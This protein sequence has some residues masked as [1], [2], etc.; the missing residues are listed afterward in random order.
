MGCYPNYHVICIFFG[1]WY[2]SY[3]MPEKFDFRQRLQ[4]ATNRFV[5]YAHNATNEL[6]NLLDKEY[7]CLVTSEK[8]RKL[9]LHLQ[10]HFVSEVV[11][12]LAQPDM[13]RPMGLDPF[14]MALFH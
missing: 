2:N 5:W 6:R 3:P 4:L 7:Y 11:P 8:Q 14:E 1:F 9:A 12:F 13:L 10:E